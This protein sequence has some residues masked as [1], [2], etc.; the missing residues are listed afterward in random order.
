V[1]SEK[2]GSALRKFIEHNLERRTL[3]LAN[4]VEQQADLKDRMAEVM[5]AANNM[6]QIVEEMKAWLEA[7]P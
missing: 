1:T 2:T 4:L 7:N 3:E 6:R 5:L